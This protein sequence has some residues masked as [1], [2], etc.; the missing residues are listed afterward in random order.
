V[1]TVST[2]SIDYSNGDDGSVTTT[3]DTGGDMLDSVGRH[4]TVLTAPAAVGS[5]ALEVKSQLGFRIGDAVTIGDADTLGGVHERG[6]ISGFGS[7]ILEQPTVF[8]HPAGARVTLY[9]GPKG[10]ERAS[11][12]S[13][14][15]EMGLSSAFLAGLI[16]GLLALLAL[17]L[18]CVFRQNRPHCCSSGAKADDRGQTERSLGERNPGETVINQAFGPLN[19]YQQQWSGSPPP[20]SRSNSA[21]VGRGARLA[22]VVHEQPKLAVLEAP[23]LVQLERIGEGAFSTVYSGTVGLGNGA[24][25]HDKA[26]AGLN[27]PFPP[28]LTSCTSPL[29]VAMVCASAKVNNRCHGL[30]ALVHARMPPLLGCRSDA[31]SRSRRTRPPRPT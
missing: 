8:E 27:Q 2:V 1:S 25:R 16:I 30:D 15:G 12:G 4:F 9:D 24:S 31:Q 10:S 23:S 7:V 11:D 22:S 21:A 6:T 14:S 17:L 19:G 26:S 13:G 28:L 5:V 18:L 29:Y 20:A 3:S